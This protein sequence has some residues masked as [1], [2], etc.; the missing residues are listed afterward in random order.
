MIA[1]ATACYF[2][3]AV[4]C[5]S[6]GPLTLGEPLS[7]VTRTLGR[8]QRISG[9]CYGNPAYTSCPLVLRFADPNASVLL[10]FVRTEDGGGSGDGDLVL[11]HVYMRKQKSCD[12]DPNVRPA[13]YSA[14]RWE[15]TPVFMTAGRHEV[16]GW[17][18]TASSE[19]GKE[20]EF[21]KGLFGAGIISRS[22]ACVF[23][24]GEE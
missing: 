24:L 2:S 23:E 10:T 18:R 22:T 9:Y 13:G 12:Q 5:P 11:A 15:G 8:G 7:S 21:S 14:W 3:A 19:L 17:T 6:V 20:L 1:L 4:R 16:S